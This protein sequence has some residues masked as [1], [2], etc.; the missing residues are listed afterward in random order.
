MAQH[1]EDHKEIKRWSWRDRQSF[2]GGVEGKFM[3]LMEPGPIAFPLKAT[4]NQQRRR[5][6]RVWKNYSKRLHMDLNSSSRQ[7]IGNLWTKIP[8]CNCGR[9]FSSLYKVHIIFR[10]QAV[11]KL[12][13][14]DPADRKIWFLKCTSLNISVPVD[15]KPQIL[16]SIT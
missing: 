16:L 1:C 2:L 4:G 3:L 9:T 14:K 6:E 11:W 10:V 13:R 5:G 7:W 12:W 15:I 8:L